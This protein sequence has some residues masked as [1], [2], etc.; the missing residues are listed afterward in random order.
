MNRVKMITAH[1]GCEGIP[2]HTL[3]SVEKGIAVGADCVEIDIRSDDQGR[4]WLIHDRPADFSGLVPL[5]EA[6]ALIRDSGI[7]VNCDLKEESVFLPTFA[8]AAKMGLGA[9]Q[10]VFSGAVDPKLLDT[11]GGIEHDAI[12]HT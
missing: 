3:A 6:F 1:N 11:H 8:L 12:Y 10:L 9:D 5:E 4:L 2:D 7:A